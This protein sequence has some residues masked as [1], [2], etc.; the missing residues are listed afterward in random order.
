M[1]AFFMVETMTT[2][3]INLPHLANQV[4]GVPQYATRQIMDSVKAVLIPRLQGMTTSDI[5]MAITPDNAP[6]Q[7][8]SPPGGGIAVIPVHGILVPRRGQI[9]AMCTE[10]TSYERIRSQLN[11]ALNDPSVSEIVLDINSGGG[12]AVGCKE[13]ADYIFQSR[14]TKPITAI[15]NFSAYSAAYFIAAACG[16]IIL[17]QTSGVGSIG[18]IMEHMEASK[19]EEQVGLKFTTIYR[20]DNKNNGTPHAPLSE[21]AQTMFQGMIDQ[22][23][24]V[25]TSS[26]AEYRGMTQQAVIDTQAALYNGEDAVVAGLADEVSDPQTAINSIAARYRQPAAQK[27]QSVLVRAAA[28]NQQVQM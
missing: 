12:A 26:V 14:E 3:I 13:L 8:E 1:R 15:V 17:S 27:S 24:D 4:F 9:T 19:M 10:M 5:A 18:V 21:Q 11:A 28:M 22:M 20:G 23:Y 6:V 16:R 25:F 7:E 2:K